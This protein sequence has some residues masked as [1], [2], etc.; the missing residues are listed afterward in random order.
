MQAAG[1]LPINSELM[2]LSKRQ[3]GF[4]KSWVLGP[5]WQPTPETC[6]QPPPRDKMAAGPGRG[7]ALLSGDLPSASGRPRAREGVTRQNRVIW[8]WGTGGQVRVRRLSRAHHPSR[9]KERGMKQPLPCGFVCTEVPSW[10]WRW[11]VTLEHCPRGLS[12]EIPGS[13]GGGHPAQHTQTLYVHKEKTSSLS[14]TCQKQSSRYIEQSTKFPY[15]FA[16]WKLYI[17]NI[18]WCICLQ[19]I[20]LHC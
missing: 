17:C 2:H 4:E 1:R 12:G 7:M 20:Y 9:L 16:H 13:V 5:G 11:S 18:V 8:Q 19:N 3:L 6:G 14:T 15:S 10:L